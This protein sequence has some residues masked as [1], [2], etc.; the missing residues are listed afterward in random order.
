[1]SAPKTTYTLD[2]VVADPN[3]TVN[4]HGRT[5]HATTIASGA[6][7]EMKLNDKTPPA[8]VAINVVDQEFD[9][10]VGA[11]DATAN[12]ITLS[13][14]AGTVINVDPKNTLIVVSG[15]SNP[16]LGDITTDM[17]VHIVASTVED[18]DGIAD[19]VIH[20]CQDN[21]IDYKSSVP[22][23]V[24]TDADGVDDVKLITA[25]NAAT[26][27]T[28]TPD[29]NK[30]IPA[31]AVTAS[32]SGLDPHISPANA[33][34]QAQRVADARKLSVDKVNQLIERFTDAPSLGFL[35]DSGVN[36]LQL[37][38]AAWT[39]KCLAPT[40]AVRDELNSLCRSVDRCTASDE[41]VRNA[42][43]TG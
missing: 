5:I 13:D 14:S 24:F 3:T 21:K 31:D 35:G 23:A 41:M 29:P 1:M 32:G 7:V 42:D 15:K 8:V 16:Q 26:M 12:K 27:P 11:V 22:D 2:P 34:L 36:V 6:I 4:Y 37:N 18:G 33:R 20:Y 10:G 38:L 19:R 40:G 30:P 39:R 25:F 43:P 28:I 9:G 17:N